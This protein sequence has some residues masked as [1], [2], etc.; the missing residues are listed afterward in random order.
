MNFVK[1]SFT[2]TKLVAI[3]LFHVAVLSTSCATVYDH[4]TFTETVET[5]V[6]AQNL[7]EL[8]ATP[9]ADNKTQVVNFQNQLQKM[10]VYERAK[11]KNE[12]TLKMWEFINAPNSAINKFLSLWK[13]KETLSPTFIEEFQAPIARI[14]DLMVAYEN[15]KD[16]PTENALLQ[17]LQ[18]Q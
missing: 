9:Y 17:L 12:V 16:Q 13:E 6:Q 2:V 18:T 11:S 1:R 7:I 5:K 14:F 15:K 8:A 4:Y 10:L 3:L